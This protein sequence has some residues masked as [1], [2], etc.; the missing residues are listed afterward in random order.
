MVT[1]QRM[2][3]VLLLSPLLAAAEDLN[4]AVTAS[5]KPVLNAL[6][7]LFEAQSG[8]Q[9]TLSSASTG[10]LYQQIRN[11]APFDL[12]FAADSDRP[13]KLM[14]ALDLAPERRQTYAIGRLVL[15]TT[16]SKVRDLS[17]L[18][19]YDR[20]VIIA[21]PTHAPYGLAADQVLN[22]L[23]FSGPR[24]L[25]NNVSQ[26]RQYLSLNLAG[27]GLI[28]ASMAQGLE[29]VQPISSEHHSPILQ[30]LVVLTDHPANAEFLTFLM[31]PETQAVIESYG[32]D[33]PEG[34]P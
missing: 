26:A 32:Y 27:V 16:D 21:N 7:P 13:E 18:A 3:L 17:D 6:V 34:S 30:Q 1:A 31:R 15:V 29:G 20:R 33:L 24:V 4:I 8:V 2:I 9:L 10:V 12:F 11:G 25:A 28:A 14:T 5:F 22:R 19:G 23:A